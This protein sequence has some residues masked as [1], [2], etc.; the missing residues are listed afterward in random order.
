MWISI[1]DSQDWEGNLE[2]HSVSK[3]VDSQSH[4]GSSSISVRQHSP[5]SLSMFQGTES[6]SPWSLYGQT[7]NGWV[8]PL[9]VQSVPRGQPHYC[10][11]SRGH[12]LDS[13]SQMGRPWCNLGKGE[14]GL[15]TDLQY[16]KDEAI[17]RCKMVRKHFNELFCRRKEDDVLSFEQIRF[18]KIVAHP[19]DGFR[20][21]GLEYRS[22]LYTQVWDSVK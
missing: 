1:K 10:F 17:G 22:G 19:E 2:S 7:A 5:P 16:R 14:R 20:G 4:S 13:V 6:L 11:P 18:E 12:G 9:L 3:Q 15:K 8:Y 21:A